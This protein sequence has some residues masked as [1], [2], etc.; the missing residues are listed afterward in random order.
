MIG[1]KSFQ[2]TVVTRLRDSYYCSFSFTQA[3]VLKVEF[4]TRS[5][6][7]LPH[8]TMMR[9]WRW[10]EMPQNSNNASL[11]WAW[12]HLPLAS[13][14]SRSAPTKFVPLSECNSSTRP[15][16]AMN[17]LRSLARVCIQRRQYLKMHSSSSQI[18]EDGAILFYS[19]SSSDDLKR[20][21]AIHL[22]EH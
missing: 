5:N 22:K 10:I 3:C 16:L 12:V 1:S 20:P 14:R 9:G 8:T 11:I 17:L 18:C 4:R 13:V 21:K 15:R 2:I 7:P 19:S 6:H